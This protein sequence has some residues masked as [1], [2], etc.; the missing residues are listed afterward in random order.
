MIEAKEK[1]LIDVACIRYKEVKNSGATKF[2]TLDN[3]LDKESTMFKRE[4]KKG[5]NKNHKIFRRG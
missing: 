3:W 1:D 4:T 2:S 5:N